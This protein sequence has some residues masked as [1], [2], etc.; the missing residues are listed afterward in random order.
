MEVDNVSLECYTS[1]V[2]VNEIGNK[3]EV[4]FFISRVLDATGADEGI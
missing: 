4:A 3:V 2:V 1:L